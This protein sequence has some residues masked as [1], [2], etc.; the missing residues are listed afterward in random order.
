MD[1]EGAFKRMT[2][3]VWLIATAV[4]ALKSKPCKHGNMSFNYFKYAH[5]VH[6]TES[7]LRKC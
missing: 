2:L 7:L 4:G 1:R 5:I 3:N 6:R